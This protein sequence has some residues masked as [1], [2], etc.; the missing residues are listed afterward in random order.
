MKRF[1]WTLAVVAVVVLAA[2]SLA[3]QAP[4]KPASPAG[5][6]AAQV[7]GKYVAVQGGQRYQDGKWIE[8]T[9]GRPILRG[10]QNIFGSGEEY[11]KTVSG[12][13]PVWRTGANQTTRLRTEVALVFDGKTLPAGEYSVFVELKENAWT[14]IFSNWPAQEK[15]DP[16]NKE[17]LW[18]SYGYTPDKDVLRVPMKVG[19]L[20]FL[21]DQFT[22]A[23]IDMAGDSG[24]LAMMW[25]KTI[26][27]ASF[28]AES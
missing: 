18:G 26:A 3:Q 20:P 2:G 5:T 11:G 14:L 27:T 24:Q 6:A 15:Y 8:V 12:G 19:A 7:G 21:M 10:R 25:E 23:F 22:I 1:G 13:A 16:K 9:Y 17:A 28:K 4:R